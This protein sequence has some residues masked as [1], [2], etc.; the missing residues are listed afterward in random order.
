MAEWSNAA[1]LKTVVP[2]NRDRGFES[3]FLRRPFADK[4]SQGIMR[5]GTTNNPYGE[6]KQEIPA[7]AGMIFVR[8]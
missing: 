8:R 5:S 1:V 7:C 6:S 2:R 4:P 3:L